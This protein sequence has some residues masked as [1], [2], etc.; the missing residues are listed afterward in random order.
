MWMD[1]WEWSQAIAYQKR[2]TGVKTPNFQMEAVFNQWT[3]TDSKL[4]AATIV[5]SWQ[6]YET[7]EKYGKDTRYAWAQKI[8]LLT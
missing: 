6:V 4:S 7:Q 3:L 2:L 1:M 5:L 8:S